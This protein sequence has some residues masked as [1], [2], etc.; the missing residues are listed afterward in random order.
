MSD[1]WEAEY[2]RKLK[3]RKKLENQ[4]RDFLKKEGLWADNNEFI[5]DN[6][7]KRVKALH[8]LLTV[9]FERED[10]G[11]W[12]AEHSGVA[13]YGDTKED[14]VIKLTHIIESTK[15]EDQLLEEKKKLFASLRDA[16]PDEQKEIHD[17]LLNQ[18]L[19]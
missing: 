13:V 7:V 6:L 2:Q 4:Y 8:Y 11:R 14:A 15:S 5:I 19:P 17:Q 12:I 16:G 9:E 3:A 10:D 1:T 18:P